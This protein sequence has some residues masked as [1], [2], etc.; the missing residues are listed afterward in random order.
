LTFDFKLLRSSLS[1][2]SYDFSSSEV[3]LLSIGCCARTGLSPP[4]CGRSR[5]G[6][7]ITGARGCCRL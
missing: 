7:Q 6:W 1:Q 2:Y 3:C 4:C 5:C